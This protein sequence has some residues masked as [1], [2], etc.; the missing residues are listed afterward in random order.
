[1][2]KAKICSV[3]EFNGQYVTIL[4]FYREQA[5]VKLEHGRLLCVHINNL[6]V[7]GDPIDGRWCWFKMKQSDPWSVG[8][9]HQ[10]GLEVEDGQSVTV[11]IVEE[12]DGSIR[13]PVP[14]FVS[15]KEPV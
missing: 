14:D 4:Q 6:I 10:W 13:T 5:I 11:G 3:T 15:F 1:M 8:I 7:D 2:L 12:A 9:W